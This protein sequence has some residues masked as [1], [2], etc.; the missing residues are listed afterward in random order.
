MTGYYDIIL[1]LIPLSLIGITAVLS[2]AGISLTAAVPFAATVPVALIG[3]ALFVNGPVDD[4]TSTQS[5]Q[6]SAD[7]PSFE[8]AD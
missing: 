2:A 7:S 4:I 1:G 3:H 8:P 5:T 6:S